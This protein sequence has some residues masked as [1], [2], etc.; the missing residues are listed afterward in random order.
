VDANHNLEGQPVRNREERKTQ[1]A[2]INGGGR[3]IRTIGTVSRTAVFKM[4]GLT[5]FSI[6]SDVFKRTGSPES[7]RSAL[8]R[9]F[10]FSTLFPTSHKGIVTGLAV[11]CSRT[12]ERFFLFGP[13][14]FVCW[15][16]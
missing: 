11:T 5:R 12:S 4:D 1:N 9:Q 2:A 8:N 14:A 16:V 13:W 10:L 6:G 15:Q 3:G 7:G